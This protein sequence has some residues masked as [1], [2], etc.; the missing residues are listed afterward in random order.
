MR[1]NDLPL[2]LIEEAAARLAERFSLLKSRPSLLTA[3]GGVGAELYH[4]PFFTH[5]HLYLPTAAEVALARRWWRQRAPSLLRRLLRP[6][7]STDSPSPLPPAIA[8]VDPA[9][10]PPPPPDSLAL[11]S[12]TLF[13]HR[14]PDPFTLLS[15]WR[16][17]LQPGAPLF[18][19]TLGP[20][21]L[22][23]LRP[24]R[25]SP[26][27]AWPPLYDLH[28]LGD[29]LLATGYVQPVTDMQQL[30]I[31]YA[32]PQ[33]L[34]TDWSSWLSSSAVPSSFPA[35]ITVELVFGHAWAPPALAASSSRPTSITSPLRFY[36]S[37]RSCS[38]HDP[39]PLDL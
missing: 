31:T 13:L 1:P 24:N 33:S 39:R 3:V 36:P 16:T 29:L 37:P 38:S 25:S 28:D 18:L 26:P 6:L 15:H 14:Y 8:V 5:A 27:P 23:Q 20:D 19:V 4:H 9:V 7:L 21:T 10:L 35:Q 2:W 11:L 32:N 22:R 17:H 34:Y 12:S 30:T